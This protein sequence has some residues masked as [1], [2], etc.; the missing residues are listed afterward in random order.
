LANGVG[1]VRL[2]GPVEVTVRAYDAAGAVVAERPFKDVT[3]NAPPG[4]YEPEIKG[5]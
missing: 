3:G 1:S 5:W 2:P 4:L